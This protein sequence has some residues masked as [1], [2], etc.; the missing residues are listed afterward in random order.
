M[1]NLPFDYVE[2]MDKMGSSDNYI[3][4]KTGKRKV[5]HKTMTFTPSSRTSKS[6]IINI[7]F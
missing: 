5:G 3:H 1:K 6:H 2:G 4:L 7:I